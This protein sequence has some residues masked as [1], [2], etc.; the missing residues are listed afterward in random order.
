MGPAYMAKEMKTALRA[1]SISR[2]PGAS[3]PDIE[4][5]MQTSHRVGPANRGGRNLSNGCTS[6]FTGYGPAST[7]MTTAGHCANSGGWKE[8]GSSTVQTMTYITER[9][10]AYADIQFHSFPV[11]YIQ[12]YGSSTTT[13]VVRTGRLARDGLAGLYLCHRGQTLGIP[14]APCFR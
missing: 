14:V 4:V 1:E 10:D 7:G 9:R 6:G 12:F 2:W 5:E 13:P 8:F 11:M 3:Q